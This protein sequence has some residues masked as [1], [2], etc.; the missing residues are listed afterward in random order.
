MKKS[1][2]S[3]TLKVHFVALEDF[4]SV[5]DQYGFTV[6]EGNY[7]FFKIW[8]NEKFVIDRAVVLI[9]E[10]R[11]RGNSL[12]HM[13]LEEIAQ[14]LGPAGDSNRFPESVF[15]EDRATRK[16]GRATRLSKL[17]RK[18]LRFLYEHVPTGAPAIEVGVWMAHHWDE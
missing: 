6:E 4:A 7:G 3:A 8:W 5:A 15:Y 10:D 18:T 11:L 2:E 9:A 13:V 12:Q 17:D 14:S 16:Y 1:D